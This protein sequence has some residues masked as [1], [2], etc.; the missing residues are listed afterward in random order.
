MKCVWPSFHA[1][2]PL[3]IAGS[4]ACSFSHCSSN[5]HGRSPMKN[6]NLSTGTNVLCRCSGNLLCVCEASKGWP[7]S[8]CS[9]QAAGVMVLTMDSGIQVP[10]G[11]ASHDEWLPNKMNVWC[12]STP[13]GKPPFTP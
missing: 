11:Q 9:P 13:G 4:D 2:T 1:S 6:V 10:A 7:H 12:C 5:P 3:P 8:C